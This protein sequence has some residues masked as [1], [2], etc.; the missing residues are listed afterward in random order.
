MAGE[1]QLATWEFAAGRFPS[2][3]A[4]LFCLPLVAAGAL[5]MPGKLWSAFKFGR[6]SKS[7]FSVPITAELL[8]SALEDL[9]ARAIKDEGERTDSTGFSAFCS[10]V[11]FSLLLTFLPVLAG[12]A[13]VATLT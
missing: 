12:L 9:R 13:L 5:T 2:I 10:L 1:I 11:G 4:N 8:S 6:R 3:Y 7:L